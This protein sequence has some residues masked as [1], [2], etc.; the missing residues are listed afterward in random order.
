MR[1]P[2]F[3]GKAFLAPM[4]GISDPAFRLL[5]KKR[6]ASLVVTELTSV[7]AIIQKEKELAKDGKEINEFVEFSEK[8][9]PVSVQ[10]FGNEIDKIV[11]AAEI[12]EPFFDIIDFNM[13]CPAPHITSQMAG[14]ALL[15]EP[16]FNDK[17][18]S[19]LSSAVNKPLTLKMRTGVSNNNCYLFKPI[20]KLAED[21][22]FSMVALH[23]RSVKQ[24][25]SGEADWSKIKE[26]KELVN[27][28][29]VGNGDITSPELAKKMM[30]ETGCDFVMIGRGARGN[31]DIFNQVNS[32]LKKGFYDKEVD[33]ISNFFTY[34]D[35]AKN[36]DIKFSSMKGQAM[37]F[38]KGL[39]GGSELR[40]KLGSASSKEE[41]ISLFEEFRA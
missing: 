9:R 22:G 33:N 5:C 3:K 14:A 27:I 10:L 38:T 1:L 25:Y 15:Q 19:K 32:Y 2:K 7:H 24:G 21:H 8:E 20:A 28:P 11:R 31:P 40:L 16:E 12:V 23:G 29:V 34:M 6:G 41:L 39:K 35:Y 26:L 13:G 4:S 17:L 37:Q 30:Q 36:F 18:F